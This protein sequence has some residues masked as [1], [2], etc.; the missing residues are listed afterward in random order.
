MNEKIRSTHLERSAVIYLRQSSM[1]QV[2]VH[3]ESTRRQYGLRDRAIALGW[4]AEAVEIIDEDLGQSGAST[5]GRSGFQRLAEEVAHGRVGAIFA[6]EVSRLARRSADWHRLLDLCR[7]ADV[8]IGDEQAVYAPHNYDDQLLLGL[9][10]TMAEAESTWL[11]LR[12]Q[13]GLLNKARRGELHIRP[14]TGYRWEP[15][16]RRFVLEPDEAIQG[17]IRLVFERFEIDGSAQGVSRYFARNGLRLPARVAG[18]DEHRWVPPRPDKVVK[19]LHNPVY[20]GAY[21]FGRRRARTALVDGRIRAHHVQH[22]PQRDWTVFIPDH[23]PGYITWEAYMANQDK[24]HQNRSDHR[25]PTRRGAAREGA[26]L[27][28]GLVICGRCGQRMRTEYPRDR[29]GGRYVCRSPKER[30]GLG[31]DCWSLTASHPDEAVTALFLEAAQ[32]PEIELGLAVACEAERQADEVDRQWKLRIDQARYEARLAERRY[33]AVDPDNRVVAR[34]LEREWEE[35]LC[36]LGEAETAWQ[37]ARRV[38]KTE[39][40]HA[41]RERI[42][43]LS[44]DL[45][46]VW[47]APSTTQAQRKTLLR[48]L[49]S[50]VTL[51]PVD[52]PERATR[53]QVL[54]ESGAVSDFT[55]D[56]P[57]GGGW[58][59]TD[60]DDLDLI[61][62]WVCEGRTDEEIATELAGCGRF[63]GRGRPWTAKA[64]HRLRWRHRIHPPG[65]MPANV[66]RPDQREDGLW[67]VNGITRRFGVSRHAV[68]YWVKQGLLEPAEGG[69]KGQTLWF[70]LDEATVER[71]ERV[72]ARVRSSRQPA[73]A[74]GVV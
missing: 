42:L 36:A 73:T 51:S 5:E 46:R 61:R 39:L 6:L 52:L 15:A 50:E 34:T 57:R 12:L 20:A 58:N 71:L 27:L 49:V 8:V 32:P 63:T 1:L 26:A 10:G 45:A 13:G 9:K 22:L 53:V 54:W 70:E 72:S 74:K 40:T 11:R 28:Q 56:R 23:H 55:I 18:T 30:L 21:V 37:E 66:R 64:V 44:R 35:K 62:R 68:R 14:P 69:E 41:D 38:E 33:K 16:M 67:S 25:T 29:H 65:W 59:A 60:Q 2:R 4:S 3:R 48:T 24:L 31:E 47:H 7:L 17:A 43:A 19:M